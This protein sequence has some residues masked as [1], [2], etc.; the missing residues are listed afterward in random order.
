M[1]CPLQRNTA[2]AEPERWI[3]PKPPALGTA[4]VDEVAC[5]CCGW[6][7]NPEILILCTKLRTIIRQSEDGH[8]M[9]GVSTPSP[10]T[11]Q[12]PMNA[13]QYDCRWAPIR[14]ARAAAPCG[15]LQH[16]WAAEHSLLCIRGAGWGPKWRSLSFR[17]RPS[18]VQSGWLAWGF[19]RRPPEVQSGRVAWG[20]IWRPPEVQSGKVAWGSR[21]VWVLGAAAFESSASSGSGMAA[22]ILG[23]HLRQRTPA[24]DPTSPSPP[25]PFAGLGFGWHLRR[26]HD[27]KSKTTKKGE[28][29][30]WLS[31]F[32]GES[33][34][35]E[36][37]GAMNA[38]LLLFL[39]G[40]TWF[41][42]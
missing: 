9:A 29:R 24:S 36:N 37:T 39:C 41:G 1:S 20:F 16:A 31:A 14:A 25:A 34:G 13:G 40:R 22:G 28:T 10:M 21:L 11:M 27:R 17:R 3:W 5:N 7:Y 6:S 35:A 12:V 18:E 33:V 38:V 2:Q 23:Q 8:E 42:D 4:G 15:A 32:K 30:N 26:R 19:R